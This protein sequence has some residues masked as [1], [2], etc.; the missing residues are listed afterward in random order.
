MQCMWNAWLHCPHTGG[1]SS[2]GTEQSGQVPSNSLRQMPQ[3]SS[4]TSHL[5][6]ATACHFL[7]LTFMAAPGRASRALHEPYDHAVAKST[8]TTNAA[9]VADPASAQTSSLRAPPRAAPSVI[10][11]RSR[12]L[13]ATGRA[14]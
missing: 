4:A 1:Q 9:P 14:A 13:G 3:Q 6:D 10:R 2:P 12:D 11:R 7:I 5:H 8:R